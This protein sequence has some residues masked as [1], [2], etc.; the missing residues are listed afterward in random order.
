MRRA[1][2]V[3]AALAII[4]VAAYAVPPTGSVFPDAL[5]DFQAVARMDRWTA[6]HHNRLL[7]A[8]NE[9]QQVMLTGGVEETA[10]QA[11]SVLAAERK[12]INVALAQTTTGT[13]PV[14]PVVLDDNAPARIV[15]DGPGNLAGN[16]AQVWV[17]NRDATN[18]RSGRACVQIVRGLS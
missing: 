10:C 4:A 1:T 13:E 2:A 14:F 15:S 6:E 9:I 16:I 17:F 11:F 8:V 12:L 3:L 5:D 7:D 18:A